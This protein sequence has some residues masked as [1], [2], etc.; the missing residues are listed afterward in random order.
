MVRDARRGRTLFADDG[1]CR[2]GPGAANGSREHAQQE[3][4]TLAPA[5]RADKEQRWLD[6]ALSRF[7]R[8]NA[9]VEAKWNRAAREGVVATGA[10]ADGDDSLLEEGRQ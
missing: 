6:R 7:G 10:I 8:E 2:V 5:Q 3:F 1:E 4:S 9:V